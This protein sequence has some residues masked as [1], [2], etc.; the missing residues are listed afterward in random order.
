M[1]TCEVMSSYSTLHNKEIFQITG[2]VTSDVETS[3]P[4]SSFCSVP[5]ASLKNNNL[6]AK[7]LLINLITINQL[8]YFSTTHQT[9]YRKNLLDLY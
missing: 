9:R 4:V 8:F 1:E 2:N 5:D 3:N 7:V 6:I